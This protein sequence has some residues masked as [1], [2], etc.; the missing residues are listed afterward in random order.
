MFIGNYTTFSEYPFFHSRFYSCDQVKTK[1]SVI[2]ASSNAPWGNKPRIPKNVQWNL[3]LHNFPHF[4]FHSRDQ[5]KTKQSVIR[6]S[7]DAPWG[8]KPRNSAYYLGLVNNHQFKIDGKLSCSFP[9]TAWEGNT[10]CHD[11]DARKLSIL[12]FPRNLAFYRSQK[13]KASHRSS[14]QDKCRNVTTGATSASAVTPKLSDTLTLSKPRGADS[15]HHCR[16]RS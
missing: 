9:N 13:S 10:Q 11:W 5:V 14:I 8:V 1:Q 7:S 12:I 16:G 6:A 4:R 15:A 3:K 2:R